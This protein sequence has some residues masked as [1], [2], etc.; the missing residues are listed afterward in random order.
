[1][2]YWFTPENQR[3][4]VEDPEILLF[5]DND[6]LCSMQTLLQNNVYER[7]VTAIITA[8]LICRYLF[9][10]KP[11][12]NSEKIDQIKNTLSS[13]LS[14]NIWKRINSLSITKSQFLDKI[15]DSLNKTFDSNKDICSQLIKKY[16]CRRFDILKRCDGFIPLENKLKN[17]GFII[18]FTLSSNQT[19]AKP[20]VYDL[21]DEV[22]EA[23]TQ[24]I[25]E[26]FKIHSFPKYNV[27]LHLSQKNF[28]AFFETN[29]CISFE[30][31]S[32]QLPVC[33]AICKKISIDDFPD[34]NKF[35]VFATGRFDHHGYL[36]PVKTDLKFEFLENHFTNFILFCPADPTN[37]YPVQK[38]K[39]CELSSTENISKILSDCGEQIRKEKGLINNYQINSTEYINKLS[40][41]FT[42]HYKESF[43][44]DI[45]GLKVLES[46]LSKLT[47]PQKYFTIL[48]LLS[49][50]F[51]NI[52]D[53]QHA[54]TYIQK[55]EEFVKCHANLNDEYT[56]LLI[57]R[58]VILQDSEQLDFVPSLQN[59]IETSLYNNNPKDNERCSWYNYTM[60]QVYMFGAVIG[61]ESFSAN[62][63]LN[64][65]NKGFAFARDANNNDIPSFNMAKCYNNI[66]LFHALFNSGSD[67]ENAAFQ[68]AEHITDEL[69]AENDRISNR[70]FLYK[71][72]ALA[73]YRYTLIHDVIP[74]FFDSQFKELLLDSF[75]NDDSWI[76]SL[77]KKYIGAIILSQKNIDDQVIAEAKK[78]FDEALV[79]PAN[80]LTSPLL[81]YL[82]VTVAAQAYYSFCKIKEDVTAKAYKA[83]ALS[84]LG[85][86]NELREKQGLPQYRTAAMWQD[87][88]E[89]QWDPK[90]PFPGLKYY[91]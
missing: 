8:E 49:F 67:L 89:A 28:K 13:L 20:A 32:L 88:L 63:A 90:T 87:Y 52:G 12:A 79:I 21:D 68:E 23:W 31:D 37:N 69:P 86:F 1:M 2:N 47:D 41:S 4:I 44:N 22:I 80:E 54:D 17:K 77:D 43:N 24:S 70:K 18:P 36:E 46:N 81:I 40:E 29:N 34:Y 3:I 73:A 55:A 25:D 7:D 74:D 60:A 26:L 59:K 42:K 10:N 27:R 5:F 71:Q 65:A 19:N 82:R 48:L 50:G 16:I 78:L 9:L 53:A 85:Q 39:I 33:L 38:S 35:A 61:D 83:Q 57:Q 76:A 11:G 30:G 56:T 62:D 15:T 66:H 64:F 72:R 14:E 51:S 45:D 58:L 91:Y 6:E 75:D 84:L